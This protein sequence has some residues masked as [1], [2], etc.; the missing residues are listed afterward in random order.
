MLFYILLSLFFYNKKLFVMNKLLINFV[1]HLPNS[2]LIL[3][4]S[5][6]FF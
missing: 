4:V 1:F 2:Y 3:S 6:T 5:P